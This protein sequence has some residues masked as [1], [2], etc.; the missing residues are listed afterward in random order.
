MI[1]SENPALFCKAAV[2]PP[3]RHG[4]GAPHMPAPGHRSHLGRLSER[5]NPHRNLIFIEPIDD[6]SNE[7]KKF[8]A[9]LPSLATHVQHRQVQNPFLNLLNTSS[10]S[11][12]CVASAVRRTVLSAT[13]LVLSNLQYHWFSSQNYAHLAKGVATTFW[14]TGKTSP[15]AS[16]SPGGS[17]SS[18][19]L[20]D[21]ELPQA[22]VATFVQEPWVLSPH[23]FNT[24]CSLREL[25]NY[26]PKFTP[27]AP[28]MPHDRPWGQAQQLWA[29]IHDRCEE[30]Q[31]HFFIV[32]SYEQW[33]FGCFSEE[34][35]RA[36]ISSPYSYD[37]DR[38]TIMERTLHW[39]LSA[40]LQSEHKSNGYIAP[41]DLPWMNSLY[42]APEIV[43]ERS[44]A[45]AKSGKR[46]L[47]ETEDDLPASS[48]VN[49]SPSSTGRLKA[50]LAPRPIYTPDIRPSERF[51]A[52]EVPLPPTSR[53][54]TLV[55]GV[56]AWRQRIP[57]RNK[58]RHK[59]RRGAATPDGGAYPLDSIPAAS[60][61]RHPAR[62]VTPS[63][64]TAISANSPERLRLHPLLQS[65]ARAR[66]ARSEHSGDTALDQTDGLS[67]EVVVA[68]TQ[69][70]HDI[71]PLS[72]PGG[73]D[74][75]EQGEPIQSRPSGSVHR[76]QPS[77]S[78][79]TTLP[80]MSPPRA[81]TSAAWPTARS[82][83]PRRTTRLIS[84][85]LR[86]THLAGTMSTLT[87]E[88]GRHTRL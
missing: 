31:C 22:T 61:F 20:C 54:P 66:S 70:P 1:P 80:L 79:M 18:L 77:H 49:P 48:F 13:E 6:L 85:R 35:T 60:P 68:D 14:S 26:V 9:D 88:S 42:V 43:G 74:L 83:A 39:V 87:E 10:D 41:R 53:P 4:P 12:I 36:F 34:W 73:H 86:E 2:L 58:S 45:I 47:T 5:P 50:S 81:I 16:E 37:E 57:A 46:R 17:T 23:D 63:Q 19:T 56:N 76:E 32:T 65:P 29:F 44:L 67:M 38:P 28:V 52:P 78:S 72:G 69:P 8:Q 3:L 24:F 15:M 55:A 7:V 71:T 75:M 82:S 84:K 62:A 27:N 33:A 21:P 59:A 51:H 25:R 64:R 40:T 11:L 30:H